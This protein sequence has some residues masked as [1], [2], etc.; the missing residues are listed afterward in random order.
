VSSAFI[1]LTARLKYSKFHSLGSSSTLYAAIKSSFALAVV[2]VEGLLFESLEESGRAAETGCCFATG[3]G[4]FPGLAFA[5]A[6]AAASN[7]ACSA[8]NSA[9]L[10][11]SSLSLIA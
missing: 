8:A 10:S 2:D 7:A 11:C 5:A 3:A 9:F 1:S 6:K 4:V